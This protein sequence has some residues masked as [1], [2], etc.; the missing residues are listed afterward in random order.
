ML[1]DTIMSYCYTAASKL[2]KP[3]AVLAL[4]HACIMTHA[5]QELHKF[6]LTASLLRCFQLPTNAKMH[7]MPTLS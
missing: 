7:T 3:G 6:L 5:L 4:G 1:C 2:D